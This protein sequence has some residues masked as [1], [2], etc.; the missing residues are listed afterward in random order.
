MYFYVDESGNTGNDLFNLDQP[1]LGYGVVSTVHNLD[2]AGSQLHREMLA[3]ADRTDLHAKNMRSAGIQAIAPLLIKLHDDLELAF[4]FYFI[5][6][7]TLAVVLFFDAVYD[8]GLNPAV[9]WHNYWTPLRFLIVE[10]LSDVMDESLLRSA[11]DLC[12]SR[13]VQSRAA[14][15]VALLGK[16]QAR[17]LD[18]DWD[19]RSKEAFIQPLCYGISNPLSLDFGRPDRKLVSPNAVGFQFVTTSIGRRLRS[20]SLRDATAIVVD[21]QIEFNQAQIE[22]HRAQKIMRDGM[23]NASP[24]ERQQL[25]THPLYTHLDEDEILGLSIPSQDLHISSSKDSIGLQIVDLYLW[26][27]QRFFT[28]RLDDALLPLASYLF[29]ES[30]YD[31]ISL[32]G[33]EKRFHRYIESMP[34]PSQFSDADIA[35][36]KKAV[37]AHR[38]KFRSSGPP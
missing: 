31:S 33:M 23:N 32:G 6:K 4:D 26:I 14:D 1:I 27:A 18:T 11:W 3:M 15:I 29:K 28:Q 20:K 22:T 9:M 24:V 13:D 7:R 5:E 2:Q 12:T 38:S 36:A 16:V 30:N 37:E 8:A 25:L 34:S 10:G 17:I 19:E 21:R 35:E